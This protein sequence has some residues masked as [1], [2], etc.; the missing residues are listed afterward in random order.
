MTTRTD[1]KHRLFSDA[2]FQKRAFE[3]CRFA[4]LWAFNT[5]RLCEIKVDGKDGAVSWLAGLPD[6][7]TSSMD[8]GG[9]AHFRDLSNRRKALFERTFPWLPSKAP[10]NE[11]TIS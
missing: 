10:Q 3:L 5:V 8:E 2:K 7:G 1:K 9:Q 4:A 11:T 6:S